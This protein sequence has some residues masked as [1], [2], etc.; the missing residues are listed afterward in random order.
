MSVELIKH[1][2]RLFGSSSCTKQFWKELLVRSDS[3]GQDNAAA[4][5]ADIGGASNFTV[6]E[7][8]KTTLFSL[9]NSYEVIQGGRT[10]FEVL[11]SES[12]A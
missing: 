5:S 1:H 11:C 2:C 7:G 10:D 3:L 8:S 6:F 4:R 9:I 12:C